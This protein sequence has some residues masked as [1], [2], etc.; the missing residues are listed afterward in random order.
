MIS[1]SEKDFEE[2]Y[3]SRTAYEILQNKTKWNSVKD[4]LPEPGIP[5]LSIY[6]TKDSMGAATIRCRVEDRDDPKRVV[7]YDVENG[8]WV[9]ANNITHWMPMPEPPEV[10]E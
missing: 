9:E 4:C 8:I 1:I 7:W 3:V 10:S 5:V 6:R 2:K